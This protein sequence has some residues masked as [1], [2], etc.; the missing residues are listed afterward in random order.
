MNT[1]LTVGT[2]FV[3]GFIV[4]GGEVRRRLQGRPDSNPK[5]LLLLFRELFSTEKVDYSLLVFFFFFFPL[6]LNIL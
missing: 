5:R 1:Q 3:R 2:L 4:L 6:F